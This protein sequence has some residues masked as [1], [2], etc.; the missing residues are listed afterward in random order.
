MKPIIRAAVDSGRPPLELLLDEPGRKRGKWDG[1]LI[2]ALYLCD[3]FE[4]EGHP[5][6]I[7][8]SDAI[9]FEAKRKKFRSRAVVEAAQE[10]HQK[11]D[12]PE[13]GVSFYAVPRLRDGFTWPTR[14]EW[15]NG[16]R[17][18]MVEDTG[19]SS[20]RALEAEERAKAKLAADPEAA[21]IL[22]EF[23][24]KRKRRTGKME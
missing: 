9:Y 2:K 6:W 24:E 20:D 10:A 8:E 1:K 3:A 21:A 14:Q 11:K 12:S 13:K 22:A 18:E 17:G 16:Q 7:E 19:I 5:V 4:V 15:I 23:E